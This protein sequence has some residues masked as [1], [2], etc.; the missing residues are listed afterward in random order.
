MS[1]IALFPQFPHSSIVMIG[2]R[3]EMLAQ[4]KTRILLVNQAIKN[5]KTRF[6]LFCTRVPTK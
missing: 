4:Y 3:T 6:L 2:T 1:L 5:K